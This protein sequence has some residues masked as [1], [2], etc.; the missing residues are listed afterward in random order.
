MKATE[1]A[2]RLLLLVP[3]LSEANG[4]HWQWGRGSHSRV[5][6]P[7]P[8]YLGRLPGRVADELELQPDAER[9]LRGL[10]KEG[11]E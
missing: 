11:P 7:A 8:I 10:S 5:L 4:W 1:P 9:K 2:R 3:A 6:S